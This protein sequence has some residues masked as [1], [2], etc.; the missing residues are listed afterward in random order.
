[1]STTVTIPN[2]QV[3]LTL[4]QLIAALRQLAPAEK[5]QIAKALLD[6]ALNA[7][8]AQLISDLYSQPEVTD[9][10]DDDILAEIQAVRQTVRRPRR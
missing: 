10:S 7:E 4:E 2:I 8:L 1:M 6:T 9:I 3:Q 5:A